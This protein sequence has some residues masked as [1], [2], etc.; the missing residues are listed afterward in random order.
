MDLKLRED[1]SS[2]TTEYGMVLLDERE[3]RYWQ[4]SNT[5]A[6][7]VEHVGDGRGVEQAIE[8]ITQRFDV[9]EP[10]VRADVEKLVSQ[11]KQVGIFVS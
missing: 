5:A 8:L 7:V 11:L 4:L 10:R 3:G 9:D 1:I 6:I 2:A